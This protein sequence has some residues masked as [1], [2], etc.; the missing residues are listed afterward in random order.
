[1][2]QLTR[3]ELIIVVFIVPVIQKVLLLLFLNLDEWRL[4]PYNEQT[5]E[6]INE[7]A[8]PIADKFKTELDKLCDEATN[9]RNGYKQHYIK[10]SQKD[11]LKNVLNDG[12]YQKVEVSIKDFKKIILRKKAV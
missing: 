4:F 8:Q 11:G 6:P 5:R 9:R 12:I 1:V 10:L 7:I 3:L 2:K